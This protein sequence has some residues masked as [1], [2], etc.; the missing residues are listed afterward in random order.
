MALRQ[1]PNFSLIKKPQGKL[2]FV[3]SSFLNPEY[4]DLKL[5]IVPITKN[6]KQPTTEKIYS[7]V[8]KRYGQ[9]DIRSK[10]WFCL[11]KNYKPGSILDVACQSDTWVILAILKDKD[12]V[13]YRN[14]DPK[15]DGLTIA[16]D[17]LAKF[18]IYNT[19]TVHISNTVVS[20]YDGMDK[21]INDMLISQG[22]NVNIYTK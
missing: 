21:L 6:M 13:P 4:G 18:A 20:E 14:P 9:V 7:Q 12:G 5:V 16:M 11:E 15:K 3:E 2:R 17:N 8:V 22:I 19:G 1:T 10:E